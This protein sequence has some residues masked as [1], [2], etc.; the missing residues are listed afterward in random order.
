MPFRTPHASYRPNITGGMK[1]QIQKWLANAPSPSLSPRIARKQATRGER[2]EIPGTLTQGGV[3]GFLPRACPGLN[4]VAPSG[5]V[6]GSSG[7]VPL[8]FLKNVQS[9]GLQAVLPAA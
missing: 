9:P 4:S 5:R 8:H 2:R 7:L 3:L 6:R 1:R